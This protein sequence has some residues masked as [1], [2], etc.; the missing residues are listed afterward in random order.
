M[1]E[2]NIDFVDLISEIQCETGQEN[3]YADEYID[4]K[5]KKWK[6]ITELIKNSKI[7]EVYFTRKTFANINNIKTRITNIEEHCTKKDIYFGY[8]PTPARF[9]NTE[10]L[11]EWK[12]VMRRN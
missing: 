8:L 5:V 9:Y 3:N 1:K 2:N 10:K 11:K 7:N 4:S 6:N 12:K